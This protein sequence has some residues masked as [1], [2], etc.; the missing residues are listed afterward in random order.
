[1]LAAAAGPKAGAG[2]EGKATPGA[3]AGPGVGI[4][5][6][7]ETRS[8]AGAGPGAR[9]EAGPKAGDRLVVTDSWTSHGRLLVTELVHRPPRGGG[10]LVN[11]AL[12]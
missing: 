7:G 5:L 6:G 10:G 1:M 8:G 12:T 3:R 11:M 2:W 4:R 9:S